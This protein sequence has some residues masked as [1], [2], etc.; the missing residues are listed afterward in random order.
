MC[1]ICTKLTQKDTRMMSIDMNTQ[2]IDITLVS[3]FLTWTYFAS[4]STVSYVNFKLV[5][6]S[7]GHSMSNKQGQLTQYLEI[8]WFFGTSVALHVCMKLAKPF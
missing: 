3:F 4:C 5:N 7:W 8:G 1:E 6:K 2:S